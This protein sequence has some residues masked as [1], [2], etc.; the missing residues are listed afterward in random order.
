MTVKTACGEMESQFVR[1]R[2]EN[3]YQQL[4]AALLAEMHRQP[5]VSTVMAM[6]LLCIPENLGHFY[7]VGNCIYWSREPHFEARKRGR[8]EVC[9]G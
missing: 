1:C 3:E 5:T 4:L 6:Y 7:F 9:F 2:E 8:L